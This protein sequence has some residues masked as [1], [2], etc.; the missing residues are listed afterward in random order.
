MVYTKKNSSVVRAWDVNNPLTAKLFNW[1]FLPLEVV[2]RWRD[3]QLQVNENYSDLRKWRSTIFKSYWLMSRFIFN[4]VKMWYLILLIKKW[5]NPNIFGTGG[6]R[7]NNP[8][9]RREK[10]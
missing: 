3:P 6:E 8:Y 2:S 10:H 4:M 1:N 7:V 5:K 9:D